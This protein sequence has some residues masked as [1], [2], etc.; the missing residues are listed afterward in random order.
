MKPRILKVQGG[1][2]QGSS[3]LLPIT[4]ILSFTQGQIKNFFWSETTEGDNFLHHMLKESP[5]NGVNTSRFS[6]YLY[7]SQAGRQVELQ[8]ST[9]MTRRYLLSHLPFKFVAS[10]NF[11]L[12]IF[13]PQGLFISSVFLNLAH[14]RGRLPS[15]F[16]AN[17]FTDCRWH[18]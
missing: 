3:I 10:I 8:D 4:Q 2:G 6:T 17:A 11:E 16:F 1:G 14:Q 5:V 13:H 12:I 18:L 15:Q 9:L 7:D